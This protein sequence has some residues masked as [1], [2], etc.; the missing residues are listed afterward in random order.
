MLLTLYKTLDGDNVINKT[1]TD[2]TDFNINLKGDVDIVNPS[3]LMVRLTGLDYKDFNYAHIPELGRYYF[4]RGIDAVNASLFRLDCECD[5]LETYK[6]EIL[7]SSGIYWKTIEAGD[8]G[9]VEI[10]K[11]GKTISKF[12]YSEIELIGSNNLILN[13][14]RG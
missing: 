2:P 3:L 1:L 5:Y 7:N 11:T 8:F 12:D 13:T 4:I 9:E 10:N 6:V 14:V